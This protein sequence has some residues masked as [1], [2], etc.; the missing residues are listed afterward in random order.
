LV[1]LVDFVL[2]TISLSV[3]IDKRHRTTR[4][5][6]RFDLYRDFRPQSSRSGS[7]MLLRLIFTRGVVGCDRLTLRFLIA[8]A[9]L[10]L[11]AVQCGPPPPLRCL[12]PGGWPAMQL[13]APVLVEVLPFAGSALPGPGSAVGVVKP[14]RIR[15]FTL[16]V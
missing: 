1:A 4:L 15:I 7:L 11:E 6:I 9:D 5:L 8:R 12:R 2:I 13:T 3:D 14:N 16:G 10:P